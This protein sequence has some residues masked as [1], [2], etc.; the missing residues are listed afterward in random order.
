MKI[1][2]DKELFKEVILLDL[3]IVIAGETK[4]YEF[5]LYNEK[6]CKLVDLK[7][8]CINKEIFINKA[9]IEMEKEEITKLILK[10]SPSVTLKEGLSTTINITGGEIYSY[11]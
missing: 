4:E 10:W 8:V 11:L 6:K 2:L 3:G 5:Y 1:F 7:F 9:P